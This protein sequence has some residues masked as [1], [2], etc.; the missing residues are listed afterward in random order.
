MA[1]GSSTGS[2]RERGD[3]AIPLRNA[4]GAARKR[5][6]EGRPSFPLCSSPS[7]FSPLNKCSP[8]SETVLCP[9]TITQC[10]HVSRVALHFSLRAVSC[11]C[12]CG[13]DGRDGGGKATEKG[14][15]L[16]PPQRPPLLHPRR[17][18][19]PHCSC[20][21]SVL[22]GRGSSGGAHLAAGRQW[23]RLGGSP[24]QRLGGGQR[25]HCAVRG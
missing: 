24:P 19:G 20:S 18:P 9:R 23:R 7:F 3:N 25:R 16:L 12:A 11:A 8:S 13:T 21:T 4:L 2:F 14:A 15:C 22:R 17:A 10:A 6:T 1:R 5:L